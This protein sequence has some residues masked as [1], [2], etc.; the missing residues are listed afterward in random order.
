MFSLQQRVRLSISESQSLVLNWYKED[1]FPLD[2]GSDFV[3]SKCLGLLFLSDDML[4]QEIDKLGQRFRSNV[5]PAAVCSGGKK[6]RIMPKSTTSDFLVCFC[7][8]PH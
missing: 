4:E 8:N 5:D 6:N 3:L 7:S 2:K 1:F